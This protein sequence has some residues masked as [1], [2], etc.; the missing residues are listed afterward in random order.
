[1]W[2]LDTVAEIAANHA[3]RGADASHVAVAR[4]YHCR[5]VSLDREQR[6]RAAALVATCTLA[7]ALAQLRLS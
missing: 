5:L 6:E 4:T 7:E 1:M 2:T 3:L